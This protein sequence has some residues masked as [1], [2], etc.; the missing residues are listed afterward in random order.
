MP[1]GDD[2]AGKAEGSDELAAFPVGTPDTLPHVV[3]PMREDVSPPTAVACCVAAARGHGQGVEREWL[4]AVA[5][6]SVSSLV[7]L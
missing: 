3:P 5:L 2:T 7:V 6:H 4:K 1:G